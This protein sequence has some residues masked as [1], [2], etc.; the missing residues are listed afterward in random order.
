MRVIDMT[1]ISFIYLISLWDLFIYRVILLFIPIL[2]SCTQTESNVSLKK[3]KTKLLKIF[4]SNRSKIGI[5]NK[6]EDEGLSLLYLAEQDPVNVKSREQLS[7]LPL[8]FNIKTVLYLFYPLHS[9]PSLY[10][11]NDLSISFKIDSMYF[12]IK[13]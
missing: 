2:H 4:Y 9:N 11:A 7:I 1:L 8:N 12:I 13:I 10:L 6:Y 3:K 5:I